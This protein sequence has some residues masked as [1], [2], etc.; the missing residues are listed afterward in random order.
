MV[1]RGSIANRQQFVV[2]LPLCYLAKTTIRSQFMLI[3]YIPFLTK[4]QKRQISEKGFAFI[5]SDITLLF[6]VS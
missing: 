4:W 1:F 5:E 3:T 2:I 6:M